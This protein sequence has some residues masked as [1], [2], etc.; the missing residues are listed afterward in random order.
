M[1]NIIETKII[2]NLKFKISIYFIVIQGCVRLNY[3]SAEEGIAI[4]VSYGDSLLHNEVVKGPNPPPSCLNIFTKLAQ[5]CA[6][7]SGLVP[8]DDGLKGCV[9]LEPMLL[10][11]A[12]LDLPIGCFR[13]SQNGME[14]IPSPPEIVNGVP[15]ESDKLDV[16][17]N[18]TADD[19]SGP[20]SLAGYTAE[21]LLAAVNESAQQGIALLTNWLGIAPNATDEA[22]IDTNNVSPQQVPVQQHYV[23]ESNHYQQYQHQHQSQPPN[24][25]HIV[26]GGKDL[27][28]KN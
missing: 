24:A 23:T 14:I 19:D 3:L 22:T 16:N 18:S 8:I 17:N 11:E 21:D 6:R 20:D 26:F 12:Q 5:M 2:D 1:L 25:G 27:N 28:Q 13:M 10:G 4:N 7:F 15:D 9:S